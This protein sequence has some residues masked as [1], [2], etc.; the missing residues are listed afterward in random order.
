MLIQG[1]G[2]M[3]V[4]LI[5]V[6]LPFQKENFSD[7]IRQACDRVRFSKP[8]EAGGRPVTPTFHNEN[9]NT[10][11][12]H[13]VWVRGQ[14]SPCVGASHGTQYA[15]S[16]GLGTPRLGPPPTL[17]SC[18]D[19]ESKSLPGTQQ[20]GVWAILP[21]KLSPGLVF[22]TAPSRPFAHYLCPSAH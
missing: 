12:D 21:T 11:Q 6:F 14:T 10:T 1:D 16:G 9:T 4:C 7:D 13:S 18:A 2:N 3:G 15:L 22:L 5:L 20:G 17:S 19:D 8:W